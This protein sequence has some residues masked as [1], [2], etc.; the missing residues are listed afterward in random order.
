MQI[1][2]YKKLYIEYIL[3]LYTPLYY[4]TSLDLMVNN[5]HIILK[6]NEIAIAITLLLGSHRLLKSIQQIYI[7]YLPVKR[8]V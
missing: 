5:I 3:S 8:S 6:L 1:R 2:N 7:G 4:T